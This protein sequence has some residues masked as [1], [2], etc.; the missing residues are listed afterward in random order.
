MPRFPKPWFRKDRSSWYVQL[1]GK[2]HNLGS[3]RELAF[4][5]Y[6]DLM[7]QPRKRQVPS[8]TVPAVID[9]FLDWCQKNR[10][11]RTY[12]WYQVRCQAF[13]DTIAPDLRVTDLRPHHL[14]TW[15]D[16]HSDWAPG[17]REEAPVHPRERR[18]IKY[19]DPFPIDYR[20]RSHKI[21]QSIIGLGVRFRVILFEPTRT[22]VAPH[23]RKQP[24]LKLERSPLVLVLS[25]IRFP[26]VL[27]MHEYIETIQDALRGQGFQRFE[28]EQVQ[29]VTFGGP[30]PK[31]EQGKRWVFSS[32]NKTEAVVLAPAF[33]VYETTRYDVFETFTERFSP[34]LDL[35]AAETHTE[36]AERV[37]LRY[38]DLIRPT[39]NLQAS[40]FL[41]ERVRGLSQKDL[42]AKHSRHQF[43]TQA[44][45]EHGD[46]NVRSF[47][48]TGTE[49]LPPD[50][51]STH[52]DFGVDPDELTGEVYRILDVDHIAKAEVDFTSEALIAKLW[53]LHEYS[54]K[55]FLA[56]VTEDAIKFWKEKD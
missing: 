49:F 22:E 35:I 30:A 51:V 44:T 4:K 16:A 53:E 31:V 2:Q 48:N 26:A 17:N 24:A 5:R 23:M 38:L 27:K 25:Q 11:T 42:G 45:T 6:H 47:E 46:L 55:A 43:I 33:V 32:R 15:V 1:D 36:F 40:E 34:V 3:D 14:Q 56:A 52:L 10:A 19:P 12:D 54:S 18:P 9:L 41:R 7:A 39:H 21:R 8:E 20:D 13:V 37:G 29:Q 28:E 50:L